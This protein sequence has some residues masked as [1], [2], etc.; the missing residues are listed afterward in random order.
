MPCQTAAIMIEGIQGE[1]G[2]MPA[3]VDY[4]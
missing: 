1:G 4:L 2:I 3:S